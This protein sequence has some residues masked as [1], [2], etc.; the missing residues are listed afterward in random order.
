MY[1]NIEGCV[2]F[3]LLSE[4]NIVFNVPRQPAPTKRVIHINK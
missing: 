1:L 2:V 4:V 3:K